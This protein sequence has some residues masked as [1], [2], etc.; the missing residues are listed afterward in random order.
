MNAGAQRPLLRASAG[1]AARSAV[2]A[3]HPELGEYFMLCDGDCTLLFTENETNTERLFGTPNAS[4]YVKDG[5]N[6][7]V[8]HGR[9]EGVNPALTGTKAAAYYDLMVPAGDARSVRVRI[10]DTHS[11]S[12]YSTSAFGRGFEDVLKLRREEADRYYATVIPGSIGAD[13]KN[14]MRQA[15]A[16]MLWSK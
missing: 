7:A 16:R 11:A 14:I 8:V 13:A 10:A 1:H 15:L 3:L 2:S 4:P 5:I 9:R 12:T 6:D